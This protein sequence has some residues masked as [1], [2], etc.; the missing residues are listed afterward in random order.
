MGK[1]GLPASLT[2]LSVFT[3]PYLYGLSRLLG[4]RAVFTLGMA[5]TGI[6][7]PFLWL[8]YASFKRMGRTSAALG[9][10]FLLLAGL[11]AAAGTALYLMGAAPPPDAWSG[12]SILLLLM[13]AAVS[14][15]WNR[16]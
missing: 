5:M 11:T 12:V 15:T 14:F 4:V 10:A 13:A 6:S 8:I 2:A 16:R 7:V 3:V 9:T 1:R